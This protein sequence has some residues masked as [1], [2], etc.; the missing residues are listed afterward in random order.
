MFTSQGNVI[1]SS[2]RIRM[3][4]TL[5]SQ[6][7]ESVMGVFISF[8]LLLIILEVDLEAR[9]YPLPKGQ[10]GAHCEPHFLNLRL[11]ASKTRCQFFLL[12]LDASNIHLS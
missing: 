11:D 12:T 2:L 8:N 3:M 4:Q 6:R 5:E 1:W 10:T 9:C 7:F